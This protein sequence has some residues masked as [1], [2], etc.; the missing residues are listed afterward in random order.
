[1]KK[2]I[3]IFAVFVLLS[4]FSVQAFAATYTD[5]SKGVS[6]VI[7]A[8][9]TQ[10]DLSQERSY[11]DVKYVSS[12]GLS[13]FMFGVYDIWDNMSPVEKAGLSR[14]KINNSIISAEEIA[15][16]LGFDSPSISSRKIGE[17]TYYYCEMNM[18]ISVGDY[19]FPYEIMAAIRLSNGYGYIFQMYYLDGDVS[20]S[21]FLTFVRSAK[22]PPEPTPSPSPQVAVSKVANN[23]SFASMK[24]ELTNRIIGTILLA[25]LSVGIVFLIK[26]IRNKTKAK[27]STDVIPDTPQNAGLE[28]A[29]NQLETNLCPFCKGS[30]PR[31]SKYCPRCGVA[32]KQQKG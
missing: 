9:W 7:P 25:S 22:Y 30:I 23:T 6:F 17:Y 21:D 8:G 26:R 27:S 15:E 19:T 10:Q 11:I 4:L 24:S 13:T 18:P 3:S 16:S 1:M 2:T 5:E 20:E 28:I 32:I 14:G 31:D 29:G 12:S